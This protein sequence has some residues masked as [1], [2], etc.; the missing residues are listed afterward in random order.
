MAE[1]PAMRQ[2]NAPSSYEHA[3]KMTVILKDWI[4]GELS[5]GGCLQK[6][7]QAGGELV[8]PGRKQF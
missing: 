8:Q 2:R 3:D 7:S 4:P 5:H 6:Q 1:L